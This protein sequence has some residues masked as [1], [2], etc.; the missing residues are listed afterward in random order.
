MRV[1]SKLQ[2]CDF[3]ASR[4]SVAFVN[5]VVAVRCVS[6]VPCGHY[7]CRVEN[8]RDFSA[9]VLPKHLGSVSSQSPVRR[10]KVLCCDLRPNSFK[11]EIY[12]ACSKQ[13]NMPTGSGREFASMRSRMPVTDT[14]RPGVAVQCV[15]GTRSGSVRFH[16]I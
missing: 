6:A 5:P 16:S 11:R 8:R 14:S 15:G 3:A 13:A 9:R 10:R 2:I 7:F 12:F 4:C 1:A